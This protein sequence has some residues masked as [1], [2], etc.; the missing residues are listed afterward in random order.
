MSWWLI[1]A[2]AGAPVTPEVGAEPA[3]TSEVSVVDPGTQAVTLSLPHMPWQQAYDRVR[4]EPTL[5]MGL[6]AM[7]A[8][9]EASGTPED[10]L[11][12]LEDAASVARVA[13]GAE[14][15]GTDMD[16]GGL[17][18]VQV[19]LQ[20]AFAKALSDAIVASSAGVDE[21]RAALEGLLAALR[22][23]APVGVPEANERKPWTATARLTAELTVQAQL[24][25]L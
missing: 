22:L 11:R 10:R 16:F 3:E 15:G 6:D 24:E 8:A 23:E 20:L 18:T 2:C 1:W 7:V 12:G 14:G 9:L 21:K 17:D 13:H 25:A 19:D 5:S 4:S